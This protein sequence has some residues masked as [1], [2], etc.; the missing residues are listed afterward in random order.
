MTALQS[1][2]N[3]SQNQVS[4]LR[5]GN[6]KQSKGSEEPSHLQTVI[7]SLDK[8]V[9][10]LKESVK[11]HQDEAEKTSQKLSDA[12]SAS[13]NL[14]AQLKKR[15]K[16]ASTELANLR[17]KAENL[18][19]LNTD[20]QARLNLADASQ[21]EAKESQPELEQKLLR[22]EES[23]VKLSDENASLR[24]QVDES[25]SPPDDDR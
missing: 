17:Q 7:G 23:L 6:S 18:D 14:R 10:E 22:M 4:E 5:S 16:E 3:E 8:E 21:I 2:L 1:K 25:R 9:R 12:E 20:L 24:K 13:A 15:E 19:Q 11:L